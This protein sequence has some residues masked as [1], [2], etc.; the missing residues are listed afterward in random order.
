MQLAHAWLGRLTRAPALLLLRLLKCRHLMRPVILKLFTEQNRTRREKFLADPS[1]LSSCALSCQVTE[2]QEGEQRV[3]CHDGEQCRLALPQ[4]DGA[5]RQGACPWNAL[6]G[7]V[8]LMWLTQWL[9]QCGVHSSQPACAVPESTTRC[10]LSRAHRTPHTS[11]APSTPT[12]AS[13]VLSGQSV[14]SLDRHL[15]CVLM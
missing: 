13:R 11:S 12:A 9:P 15:C 10:A 8:H 3:P 1:F 2:G 7:R 14:C 5:P 4:R 6:V